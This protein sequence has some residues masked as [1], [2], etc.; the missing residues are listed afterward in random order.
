M[1]NI[2]NI[3]KF[4]TEPD[5]EY[6]ENFRTYHGQN[7][8]IP[9]QS[10]LYMSNSKMDKEIEDSFLKLRTTART[11]ISK[12]KQK[13]IYDWNTTN[14]SFLKVYNELYNLGIKHNKFFLRIFDEDLCGLDIYNSYMP[15]QLQLKV[16]LECMINPWYWLRE[17]CR[18]PQDGT[19]I[20]PGGGVQY[21]LDRNNLACWYLMLN[22]ISF[23]QSKP[24]QCGKTQNALAIQ[25]Y[26]YHFGTSSATFLFF[27]KDQALA[28]TNLYRFKTQ[29]DLLPEWMQMRTVVDENGKIDKG[30]ENITS[31]RNPVTSNTIKVM[32][33]A[34]SKET[35][36][37]LGRGETAA[38]HHMD[39][40]DFIKFAHVIMD[41][42][43]F[44][45]S[46]ASKASRDNGGLACRIF[47][48]TPGDSN[49]KEGKE[50]NEWISKMV[51]WEDSFFDEPI[52]KIRR[53]INAPKIVP[54]VFVEHTWQELGKTMKWYE[55][56]CSAAEFK[57]EVIL[58]EIDLK[59]IPGVGMSPF[60]RKQIMY[61]NR[62][63][64]EPLYKDD[65]SN[66]LCPFLIYEEL[67]RSIPYIISCDPAD[68]LSGDNYAITV[69][70][71]CTTGAA[72]EMRTPYISQPDIADMIIKFMDKY[73]PRALIVVEN[74][75]GR[76][77]LNCLEKSKY[78][79]N[80]YYDIDKLNSIKVEN[81]D[82]YGALRKN[83]LL[84]RA[85]GVST[86]LSTR[87]RYFSILH[88]IVE[89]NID[90]IYSKY[91]A[92]DV[93]GLIRKPGS[94][95]IEAGDG[96]HDDNILSY[97]VGLYVL[98]NAS[99]LEQWGIH[100]GMQPPSAVNATDDPASIK[101]KIKRMIH[102]LPEDMRDIFE[103]TANEKNTVDDAWA[104]QEK[105]E[106]EIAMN[107]QQE[108]PSQYDSSHISP[109][110]NPEL[111]SSLWSNIDKTIE[112][113][114]Y[115]EHSSVDIDNWL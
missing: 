9:S 42:A 12:K 93:L 62:H 31:M 52:S 10:E 107:N 82:E 32:P 76:E 94:G 40:V 65:I 1:S 20:K 18:I 86:S 114:N 70:N 108:S 17:V 111:D 39:E 21:V 16:I 11:A 112:Q 13:E 26:A 51:H 85:W 6:E 115:N 27:N 61:I 72:A 59:R 98:R 71:P 113:S 96:S 67:D 101:R 30:V 37:R 58:R 14:K 84:R 88:E 80:I 50:A 5:Y 22:G 97:L 45:Y 104:Y 73:C 91:I 34:T 106:K 4:T 56:Q 89:Q 2:L 57:E 103:T 81:T 41:S 64:K 66:L 48:S 63:I 15:I 87:P 110:Y 68:G 90:L 3:D 36:M 102:L 19:S 74:N 83:A 49:T 105:I 29:R 100:Y 25:N 55:E 109:M 7:D 38:W 53:K 28:K 33:A 23:Y 35:A 69:I 79:Q 75:R 92:E 60:T 78:A 47:T 44:S 54:I 43:V 77:T 24:R 8:Y 46:T 95:R 99:N